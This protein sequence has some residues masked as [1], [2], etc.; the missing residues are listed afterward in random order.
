MKAYHPYPT[1]LFEE[2]RQKRQDITHLEEL[3]VYRNAEGLKGTCCWVGFLPLA[4]MCMLY[5]LCEFPCTMQ[6]PSGDNSVS[7]PCCGSA[8]LFTELLDDAN[9]IIAIS[10]INQRFGCLGLALVHSH[11][12]RTT[13]CKRKSSLGQIELW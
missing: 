2:L 4:N 3:I 12:K 6:W 13:V 10:S 11:I 1:S 9:E 7:V 8:W 5:Y